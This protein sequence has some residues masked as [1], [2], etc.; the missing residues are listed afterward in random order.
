M[1][2]PLR[3]TLMF[4]LSQAKSNRTSYPVGTPDL[5]NLAK[6]FCDA[7]NKILWRDDA[8]IVEL[9]ISKFWALEAGTECWLE[10]INGDNT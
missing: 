10:Q 9:V 7:M 8:Q 1:E 2:G 4:G 3:V 6:L 5:D